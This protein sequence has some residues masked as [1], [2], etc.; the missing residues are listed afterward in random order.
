MPFTNKNN[1]LGLFLV[2][3]ALLVGLSFSYTAMQ[4]FL[5]L[6]LGRLSLEIAFSHRHLAFLL[7][8]FSA[9]STIALFRIRNKRK[10]SDSILS[11][12]VLPVITV[13]FLILAYGGIFN[14]YSPVGGWYPEYCNQSEIQTG[15]CISEISVTRSFII[16]DRRLNWMMQGM[17]PI[18]TNH[19]QLIRLEYDMII[20]PRIIQSDPR[21]ELYP[22]YYLT[23]DLMDSN[24]I[25]DYL[26]PPAKMDVSTVYNENS[27]LA[28]IFTNIGARVYFLVD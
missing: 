21:T 1:F 3:S 26:L 15:L 28:K 8:P 9:M 6:T 23:S 25:F 16:T 4:G 2:L 19:L 12:S 11:K 13:I 10:Q 24:L 17:Y 5:E 20:D 27:A 14:I 18:G 7:I 22:V